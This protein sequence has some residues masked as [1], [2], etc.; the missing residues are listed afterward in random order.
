[1]KAIL[2]LVVCIT[3]PASAQDWQSRSVLKLK[4]EIG[5]GYYTAT[6]SVNNNKALAFDS[7]NLFAGLG[8][9]SPSKK[10]WLEVMGQRQWPYNETLT[11]KNPKPTSGFWALDVRFRRQLTP[12]DLTL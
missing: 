3:I 6:Y 5:D 12:I 8:Y 4:G 7:T 2:F 11:A 1:M 10:W 9:Q